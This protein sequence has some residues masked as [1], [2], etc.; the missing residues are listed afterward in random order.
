MQVPGGFTEEC[1]ANISGRRM[2]YIARFSNWAW[3]GIRCGSGFY[4]RAICVFGIEDLALLY[5][6]RHIL[7]NKLLPNFDFGAIEC[8]HE[9]AFNRTYRSKR[10]RLK[11]DDANYYR[12]LPIVRYQKHKADRN[13][14]KFDCGYCPNITECIK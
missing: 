12:N 1:V 6:L 10:N 14:S 4:R 2:P 13:S 5:H 9:L 3:E 8:L 11:I 7:A